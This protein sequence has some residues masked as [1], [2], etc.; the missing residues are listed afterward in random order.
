MPCI[1]K[2]VLGKVKLHNLQL[3]KLKSDLNV[4]GNFYHKNKEAQV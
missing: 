2:K 4:I 1:K 3:L